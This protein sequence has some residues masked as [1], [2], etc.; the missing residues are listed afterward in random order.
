MASEKLLVWDPL[1]RIFHWTLVAAF[2]MAYL[3]GEDAPPLHEWMGYFVLALV[4]VRVVWGFIGPE[5]ARFADFVRGPGLV[6]AN[7]RDVVL[8]RA[9]RYLGHSPAGGAMVIVL[10]AMLAATSVTG[11]LAEQSENVAAT[12]AVVTTAMADENGHEMERAGGEEEAESPLVEAHEVL[13]NLTLA[14]VF[15]HIAGVIL[16]SFTHRENLIVAMFTGRKR[17]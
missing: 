9:K 7:L 15:L 1:V 8:L 12:A 16:A 11:I 5:H 6:L 3:T 13:A 10:L 4:L 2:T 14:L 17:A